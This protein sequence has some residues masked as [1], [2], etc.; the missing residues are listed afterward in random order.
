MKIRIGLLAVVFLLTFDCNSQ[1]VSQF[2]LKGGI[3]YAGFQTSEDK[4]FNSIPSLNF[5]TFDMGIYAEMF[6]KRYFNVSAELHYVVKGE[7]NNN[8]SA[9]VLQE[10]TSQGYIWTFKYSNDTFHYLSLQ[11]LPRYKFLLTN[12]DKLFLFGGPR[13]DFRIGNSNSENENS[14]HVGNFKFEFG[15]TFGIG[16][17]L[18][19]V[20]LMEFRYEYN[21]TPTYKFEYGNE[22]TTRNH[23]SISFLLGINLRKV[24]RLEL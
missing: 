2:G 22:T 20:L 14:Y 23:N 13:F 8:P 21:F 1:I 3:S 9:I 5:L 11:L 15:G 24:L 12:E 17:E 7:R 4:V 18:R 19:D 10:N 6:D 16:G